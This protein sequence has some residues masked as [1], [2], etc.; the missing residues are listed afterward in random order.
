MNINSTTSRRRRVG[1]AACTV[2]L[3]AGVGG[4]AITGS[5][6]AAEGGT[7][8]HDASSRSAVS[9]SFG[10]VNLNFFGATAVVPTKGWGL[11]TKI[12]ARNKSTG[13]GT[14]VGFSG[15]AGVQGYSLAP[16]A[17]KCI[18]GSY[19]GI[20]VTVTNLGFTKIVVTSP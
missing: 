9:A 10:P 11:S 5:A 1:L 7:A 18:T 16:S 20:P 6:S 12:C 19:F 8:H 15:G 4:G 17:T 13:L 2:A 3:V 14:H